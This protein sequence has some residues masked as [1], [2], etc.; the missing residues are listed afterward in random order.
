MPNFREVV[1]RELKRQSMSKYDLV[2][3]LK[4]KRDNGKD[5]PPV[6]IYEFLRDEDPTAINS[7]DLGIIFEVLGIPV[8]HAAKKAKRK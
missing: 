1:R 5:V 8:G 6:T 7:T 4:G 3:A 2:Q